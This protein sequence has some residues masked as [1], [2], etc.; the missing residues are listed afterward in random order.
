MAEFDFDV[1][2][3]G[4]GPDFNKEGLLINEFPQKQKDCFYQS[5]LRILTTVYFF[6]ESSAVF[7]TESQND[8]IDS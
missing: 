7:Q 4:S 6:Q 8:Q 1:V 3:I 5:H 2:V